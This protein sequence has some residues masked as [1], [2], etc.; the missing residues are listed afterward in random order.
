MDQKQLQQ[1]IAEYF[2]KLP[3]EA[4]DVFSSMEWMEILKNLSVKYNINPKELEVLATETTLVLLGIISINEY[5]EIL[6]KELKMEE[7]IKDN[8]FKEID[9]NIL[10]GIK[11]QLMN[12][13]E[14]NIVSLVDKTENKP[15]VFDPRFSS[16]PKDVQ[17]AIAHSNWRENLYKIAQKYKLSII[18]MGDLENITVKVIANEIHPDKYENELAFKIIIPKND[19]SNIVE[20]VNKNILMEIRKSLKKEWEDE[21]IKNVELVIKNENEVPLPPYA[22]TIKNEE[23]GIKNLEEKQIEPTVNKIET[24]K[25]E[26]VIKKIETPKI[27]EKQEEIQ[28]QKPIEPILNSNS[29]Q[30]ELENIIKTIQF[31]TKGKDLPMQ[32]VEDKKIIE[33]VKIAPQIQETPNVPKNIMEEKLKGATTSNNKVTDYSIPK[34]NTPSS[35]SSDP[36]R[37]VI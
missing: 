11:D 4:Q 32:T 26:E 25:P 15:L 29:A 1:K 31:P 13:F 24:I 7:S 17:E 9:E 27:V 36:Y 19:I 21:S 28:I 37:E 23:F 3:K 14:S 16:M 5:A 34:I 30:K 2:T 35:H 33:Q 20:D 22:K 10:K 6:E 12:T 8:I 18:Q